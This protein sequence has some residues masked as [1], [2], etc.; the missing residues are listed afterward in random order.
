MADT[1]PAAQIGMVK[2]QA[3][4]ST[5]S[6][7]LTFRVH[8]TPQPCLPACGVGWERFNE[9]ELGV[10]QPP[11]RRLRITD[12]STWDAQLIAPPIAVGQ[13]TDLAAM[14]EFARF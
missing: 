2:V 6:M 1:A 4:A 14:Q 8:P 7:F 9:S 13:W 3:A 12:E 5:S 11:R 10:P